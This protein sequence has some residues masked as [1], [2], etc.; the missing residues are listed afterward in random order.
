MGGGAWVE[1]IGRRKL[2]D[3]MCR[4]Q[5]RLLIASFLSSRG[6]CSM[7]L[8]GPPLGS[9]LSC[10]AFGKVVGFRFSPGTDH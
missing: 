10:P 7:V 5:G 6:H 4:T 8:R 1:G 2:L 9:V 3:L